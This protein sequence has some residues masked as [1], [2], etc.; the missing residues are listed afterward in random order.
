MFG[1]TTLA[2]DIDIERKLCRQ[3]TDSVLELLILL[4]YLL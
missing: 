1:K 2:T 3:L 4:Q